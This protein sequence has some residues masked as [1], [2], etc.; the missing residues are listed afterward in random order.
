MERNIEGRRVAVLFGCFELSL[1]LIEN[2]EKAM[3]VCFCW[4][5]KAHTHT[6]DFQC[7]ESAFIDTVCVFVLDGMIH[8]GTRQRKKNSH[9]KHVQKTKQNINSKL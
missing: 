7:D 5:I 4:I 1:I 3:F 2:E 9:I 8:I 6:P